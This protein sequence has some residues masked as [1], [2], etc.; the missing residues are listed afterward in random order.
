MPLEARAGHPTY[1]QGM[2]NGPAPT[3][4]LHCSLAHSGAWAG[5]AARLADVV[6]LT[7][8]DLPGHG[9]SGDW[10]GARDFAALSTDI[11]ATFLPDA[12]VH[13]IGHSFGAL[14]ALRLALA[15]PDRIRTLTLIEPVL[16]AATRGTPAWDAHLA[17]QAPFE[18]A[19]RAGDHTA[20]ARAFTA[21]WGAGVDW[22]AMSSRARTA[23]A[24]RMPLIAAGSGATVDEGDLILAPGRLEALTIPT[25]LIDGATSPPVIAAIHTALAARL[26]EARRITV[27]GAGH[28]VPLTHPDAVAS[29][30]GAR[31]KG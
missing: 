29:G 5:V 24:T 2:G 22:D 18:A 16:F 14:V 4:A 10:D 1:W 12:P 6:T 3:L 15:H 7:A 11:A 13:L 28:M 20:A 27:P 17:A 9:H 25:L 30:I 23:A 21:H 26:P 19:M 8:F 31:I